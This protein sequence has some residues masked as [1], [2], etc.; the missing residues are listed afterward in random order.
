MVY[1]KGALSYET[2]I[3]MPIDEILVL[4][5]NADRMNREE[6]KRIK[7]ASKKSE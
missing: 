2:L 4:R 6:E 7:K 3:S 1:Y 5:E